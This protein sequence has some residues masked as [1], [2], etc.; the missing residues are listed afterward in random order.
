M[1]PIIYVKVGRK[2]RCFS[3]IEEARAIVVAYIKRKKLGRYDWREGQIFIRGERIGR[4]D[5]DGNFIE[6]RS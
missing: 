2:K 5:Y 4:I 6:R 1:K 3:N